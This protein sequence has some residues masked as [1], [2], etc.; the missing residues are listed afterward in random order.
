MLERSL[1]IIVFLQPL[2]TSITDASRGQSSSSLL[3]NQKSYW[4]NYTPGIVSGINPV[5]AGQGSMSLGSYIP[6]VSL[7]SVQPSSMSSLGNFMNPLTSIPLQNSMVSLQNQNQVQSD[8]ISLPSS[9]TTPLRAPSP[10]R[11]SSPIDVET[12]EPDDKKHK[13]ELE[14]AQEAPSKFIARTTNMLPS[15]NN[16]LSPEVHHSCNQICQHQ[17]GEEPVET[18]IIITARLPVPPSVEQDER[19]STESD[20]DYDTNLQPKETPLQYK[21]RMIERAMKK[22]LAS[23]RSREKRK[24]EHERRQLERQKLEQRNIELASKLMELKETLNRLKPQI[25]SSCNEQVQTF[26]DQHQKN[27]GMN[28]F[29]LRPC[30]KPDCR[31][32]KNYNAGVK[33]TEV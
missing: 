27:D 6:T 30:S 32:N 23:K 2:K 16:D 5:S 7:S 1:K 11:I 18:H 20:S 25:C 21:D 8:T 26:L 12:I 31:G 19:M 4:M 10:K 3:P 14:N 29:V 9:T 22:N 24:R 28:I 13:A 17:E 33:K 15:L